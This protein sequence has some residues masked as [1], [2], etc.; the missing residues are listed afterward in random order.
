MLTM[1][2]VAHTHHEASLNMEE[3]STPSGTIMK[4]LW[5]SWAAV[6]QYK[7]SQSVSTI[8]GHYETLGAII[9][10]II[11]DYLPQT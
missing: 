11:T 9:E 2:P 7:P 3:V 8:I 5:L 10:A 1:A 6:N 4:Y